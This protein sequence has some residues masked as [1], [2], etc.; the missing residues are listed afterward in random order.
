MLAVVLWT[1]LAVT[2]IAAIAGV[3]LAWRGRRNRA[4]G[5]LLAAALGT[6]AFSLA[7]GFSI[8]RFTAVIPAVLT[9]YMLAMDRGRLITMAALV[10]ALGIY[11]ACSWLSTEL[12]V[13]G[14]I[15]EMIFGA[16]AIPLY[17]VAA[18]MAYVWS[19]THPVV[20]QHA[21]A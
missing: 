9:G 15:F 16:W 10:G 8:G 12:I 14:L 3:Q 11:I 4:L 19:V 1:G 17:A 13:R 21:P 20:R 6:A 5:L 7:A 18:V 2:I